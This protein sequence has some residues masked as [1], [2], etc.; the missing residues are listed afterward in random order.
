MKNVK[1]TEEEVTMMFDAFFLL[2]DDTE[3]SFLKTRPM[4]TEERNAKWDKIMALQDKVM[5]QFMTKK[6]LKDAYDEYTK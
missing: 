3:S 4:T 6:E 1:L 2:F 5:L